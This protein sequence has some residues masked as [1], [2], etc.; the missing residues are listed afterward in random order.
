MGRSQKRIRLTILE[1]PIQRS[2]RLLFAFAFVLATTPPAFSSEPF[3]EF[4]GSDSNLGRFGEI[5][6]QLIEIAEKVGDEELP[7]GR[8]VQLIQEAQAK[9]VEPP[10]LV[11]ALEAELDRLRVAS[12]IL[13]GVDADLAAA[14]REA[15]LRKLSVLLQQGLPVKVLR[16][17]VSGPDVDRAVR[18]ATVLS[19]VDQ[20]YGSSVSLLSELGRALYQSRLTPD[21]MAT[22]PSLY[23]HYLNAGLSLRVVHGEVVRNL[24]RDATFLEIERSLRLRSRRR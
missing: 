19:E 5:K 22:V 2:R 20:W 11:S 13:S 21:Q 9:G 16:S 14:E 10:L 23:L 1:V 3:L 15:A 18:V 8:F 17:A 6:S 4:L 12:G 7:G 24:R